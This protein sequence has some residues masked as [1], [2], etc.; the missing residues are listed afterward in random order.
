MSSDPLKPKKM[1]R[2]RIELSE[3]DI[4]QAAKLAGVGCSTEQVAHILGMSPATFDRRIAENPAISE[5]MAKGRD[6]AN[7]KVQSVAYQMA[8][9]GKH[10]Y[11]TTFWLRTRVRWSEPKSEER[12]QEESRGADDGIFQLKRPGAG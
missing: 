12:P 9:S 8:I 6:S 11:M 2:P 4:E 5:A 10:P 1:G 3:A 7:A